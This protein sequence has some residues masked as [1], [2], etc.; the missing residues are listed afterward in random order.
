VIGLLIGA[1]LAFATARLVA[2]VPFELARGGSLAVA[3][4]AGLVVGAGLAACIAPVRRAL[5][6]QPMDLLRHS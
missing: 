4:T 6:V 5:T 3:V 1:L 2:F